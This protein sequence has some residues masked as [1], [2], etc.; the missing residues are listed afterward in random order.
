MNARNQIVS[1]FFSNAFLTWNDFWWDDEG[2]PGDDDEE[3]GGEVDLQQHRGPPPVQLNLQIKLITLVYS[4][5][6]SLLTRN[7]V[8]ENVLKYEN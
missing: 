4:Q 5:Y 8:W 1:Q 7:P 6:S 3:A 2:D